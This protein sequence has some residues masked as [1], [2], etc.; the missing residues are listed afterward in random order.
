MAT[1]FSTDE[2][3]CHCC[4]RLPEGGISQDLLDKLDQLRELVGEPIHVTCMYRCPAH[5]RAVGGATNSR[6]LYGEA[7]DIYCDNT[8]REA[9]ADLAVEIGFGGVERN[10]DMDYVHVDVR[11]D[12][13]YWV[14]ENSEEKECD[15]KGNLL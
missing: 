14:Y 13:Y 5:N 10:R 1:Y 12:T 4:G 7:A 2:M 9:L 11:S 6:H 8:D 15:S 3:T